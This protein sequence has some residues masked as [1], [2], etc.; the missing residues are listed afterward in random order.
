M[1][2][3]NGLIKIKKVDLIHNDEDCVILKVKENKKMDL[4]KTGCMDG[5]ETL[6]RVTKGE[7]LCYCIQYEDGKCFNFTGRTLVSDNIC[8]LKELIVNTIVYHFGIPIKD[9]KNNNFN[10]IQ[11]RTDDLKHPHCFKLSGWE[12]DSLQIRKDDAWIG[13]GTLKDITEYI[14]SRY[15]KVGEI[16]KSRSPQTNCLIYKI[17]VN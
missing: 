5:N 9:K 1:I 10:Y 17:L 3:Y 4:F 6:I 2:F 13:T 14:K 15:K 12:D 8:N 16:Q 11:K 7:N